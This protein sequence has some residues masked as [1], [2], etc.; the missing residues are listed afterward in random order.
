MKTP[1]PQVSA[2]PTTLR[3]RVDRSAE[4]IRSELEQ[5]PTVA[6]LVEAGKALFT[7]VL[8]EGVL[9][10]TARVPL[11]NASDAEAEALRLGT[12]E[13]VPAAV[14]RARSLAGGYTAQ[15]VA[16]PVRVL[17]SLGVRAFVLL[18]TA[19]GLTPRLRPADVMLLTDHLNLQGVN[20]LAGANEDDWGPRFPDMTAPYDPEWRTSVQ[21][22]AKD[23][24]FRQGI[25]AAVPGPA[26]ATPAERKMLQRMGADAVGTSLVLEVL[27]ARHM[28]RRVLAAVAAAGEAAVEGK[29]RETMTALVRAA[30]QTA[31]A[32]A[33]TDAA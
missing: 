28:E 15:E 9:Q 4:A 5:V 3:Q 1:E 25:Y 8:Q 22:D 26:P 2:S 12:L 27:A 13:G 7:D 10:E 30:A 18:G 20:A 23:A 17:A 33:P 31:E 29:A 11:D 24:A 6:V 14:G 32:S 21:A 19:A 16:F